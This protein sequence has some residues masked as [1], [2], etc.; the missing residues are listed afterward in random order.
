MNL[1]VSL[2]EAGWRVESVHLLHL[3]SVELATGLLD[4]WLGGA[5]VNDE[6]ESV[7][8]FNGLDNALG[9]K[10]VLD[11]CVLVESVLVHSGAC[12]NLWFA[13]KSL[14]FW[15]SK[16]N[17]APYLCFFLGMS[18]LLHSFSYILSLRKLD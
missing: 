11:K 8:V 17:F 10:W 3:D 5:L 16:G 6:D 13:I 14:G 4:G 1:N 7:V 2:L 9:S 12:E 18:S 15:E